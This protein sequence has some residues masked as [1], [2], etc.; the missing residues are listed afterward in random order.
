MNVHIGKS[1]WAFGA[2]KYPGKQRVYHYL[3]KINLVIYKS[4]S[5][6]TFYNTR[7]F[8]DTKTGEKRRQRFFEISLFRLIMFRLFLQDNRRK[9]W[10][11]WANL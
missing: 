5:K 9:S 1:D 2:I 11:L 8:S 3:P 10:D 7:S 6:P 4:Y